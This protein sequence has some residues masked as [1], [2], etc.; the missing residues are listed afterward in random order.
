[1]VHRAH[2]D[3]DVQPA[4]LNEALPNPVMLFITCSAEG[5][6]RRALRRRGEVLDLLLDAALRRG[7]GLRLDAALVGPVDPEGEHEER[8]GEEDGELVDV[9]VGL[10][11]EE[12]VAAM[13]PNAAAMPL[14]A[15]A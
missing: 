6:S 14:P 4:V 3:V 10:R 8:D 1:V 11:P 5:G 9:L 2:F 7:A 12:R 13:P 15:T